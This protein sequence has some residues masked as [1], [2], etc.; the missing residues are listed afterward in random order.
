MGRMQRNK[1]RRWEQEVA[2]LMRRVFGSR[3]EIKR[4]IAQ[5]RAGAAEAPDVD[6]VPRVWVE[7]K[8]E[9]KVNLRAAIAQARDAEALYAANLVKAGHTPGRRWPIAVCKDNGQR[10]VVVMQLDDWLAMAREWWHRSEPSDVPRDE[11]PVVVHDEGGPDGDD[12][13]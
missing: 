11:S 1:G 8:H 9:I 2:I 12:H 3:H 7:C 6:G 5:T 4:G 10:P 13:S